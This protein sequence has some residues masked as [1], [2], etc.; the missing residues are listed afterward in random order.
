MHQ[1]DRLLTR[2]SLLKVAGIIQSHINGWIHNIFL[3]LHSF[4]FVVPKNLPM[5]M[6][7]DV[8]KGLIR[9]IFNFFRLNVGDIDFSGLWFELDWPIHLTYMKAHLH[10]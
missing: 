6:R 1:R 4:V 3:K 9:L 10:L 7:G 8:N 2:L 5:G